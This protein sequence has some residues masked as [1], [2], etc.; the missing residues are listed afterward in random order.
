M[1]S[2]QWPSGRWSNESPETLGM[3]TGSSRCAYETASGRREW[4]NRD[5]IAERGGINLYGFVANNPVNYLDTLGLTMVRVGKPMSQK[6][7]D[8]HCT[9][10]CGQ[11]GSTPSSAK[12]T[13]STRN[14]WLPNQNSILGTWIMETTYT[15]SCDCKNKTKCPFPTFTQGYGQYGIRLPGDWVQGE[16]SKDSFFKQVDGILTGEEIKYDPHEFDP[17]IRPHWDYRDPNG[18]RWRIYPRYGVMYP[19]F[20][21]GAK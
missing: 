3:A 8:D 18:Q 17:R 15:C 9:S 14:F 13:T 6:E 11:F 16:F 4:L 2:D 12:I 19:D 1:G 5:P 20:G 21:R 7:C 10:Y